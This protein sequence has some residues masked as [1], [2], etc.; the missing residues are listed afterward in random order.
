MNS[1]ILTIV[2]DEMVKPLMDEFR[3]MDADTKMQ[4]SRA[5]V[6]NIEEQM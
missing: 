1:S 6:W 5:F 2:E 4:G 3:A